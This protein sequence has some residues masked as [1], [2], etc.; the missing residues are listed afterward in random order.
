M[1]S[2]WAI[3]MS[4]EQTDKWLHGPTHPACRYDAADVASHVYRQL[5]ADGYQ[6]LPIHNI[7]RD[8]VQAGLDCPH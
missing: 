7:Y 8:E 1:C 6:G 3:C 2:V 4:N 5:A